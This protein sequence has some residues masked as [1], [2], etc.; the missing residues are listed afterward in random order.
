MGAGP[1]SPGLTRVRS[2]VWEVHV[3]VP[4]AHATSPRRRDSRAWV[5]SPH[6]VRG[7]GGRP[8]LIAPL[9]GSFRNIQT[10]VLSHLKLSVGSSGS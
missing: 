9:V 4:D 10:C 7:A 5:W 2:C 8:H 6:R 1:V 3:L